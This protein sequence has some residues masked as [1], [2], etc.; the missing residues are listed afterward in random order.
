MTELARSVRLPAQMADP[1]ARLTRVGGRSG[2]SS[3]DLA[4]PQ[5]GWAV[6]MGLCLSEPAV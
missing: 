4:Q 1:F 6:P 2:P 3:V 5:P